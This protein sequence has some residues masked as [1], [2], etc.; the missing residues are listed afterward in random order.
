MFETL[1]FPRRQNIYFLRLKFSPQAPNVTKYILGL[2]KSLYDHFLRQEVFRESVCFAVTFDWKTKFH[3][4]VMAE[5][6]EK[7]PVR[8]RATAEKGKIYIQM[9][10]LSHHHQVSTYAL[11]LLFSRS[12]TIYPSWKLSAGF[13]KQRACSPVAI[14]SALCV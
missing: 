7:R 14:A 10:C 4:Q 2:V 13:A 11:G 12:N 3:V 5:P 6:G 8:N 9:S 1:N